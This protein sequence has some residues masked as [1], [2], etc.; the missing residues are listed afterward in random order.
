MHSAALRYFAV[1]ARSGSIRRASEELNVAASA[2]SRQVQKIEYELG[3]PLFERMP[4]G[5]R[6]TEAGGTCCSMP[7]T[8]CTITSC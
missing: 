4:D 2:V 1:V 7:S 6:L 3:L 5:L 8:R